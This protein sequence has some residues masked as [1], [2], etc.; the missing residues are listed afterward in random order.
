[1]SKFLYETLY[2]L[3]H[4]STR[5]QTHASLD[6]FFIDKIFPSIASIYPLKSSALLLV[7]RED[8]I[9][10][11][12]SRDS[13]L[14]KC[15]FEN[16][17][18]SFA[19]SSAQK[20]EF[21]IKYDKTNLYLLKN[22]PYMLKK[23]EYSLLLISENEIPEAFSDLHR[24]S[25]SLENLLLENERQHVSYKILLKYLDAVDDGISACDKDGNVTYINSSACGLI[26]ADKSKIIGKNL[27]HP[28]FKDTI[29]IQILKSK[30]P[31]MDFEYN[32]NYSGKPSHLMNSAYPVFDNDG[33]IMGAIDIFRRIKRSYQIASSMAGH[34]AT[35]E[36]KDFIGSGPTLQNKINLAK[37][38]SNINKNTLLEGESGTGKDLFSQ[39]IHNFSDRK[40]GP[41][42]AINCANYPIDLFDSELFGYDEGAFTGA[43]K[44][45]KSGKFELADGGTLFLDEIGEM[46]MQL[47]AKLLR[48][49]E[50][51]QVTRL[52]S[53]K[54][55][56]T[57]VRIIAATNRNLESM[58]KKKQFREDLYYRLKVLYLKIPPLRERRED[59]K[60][61]SEHF[62]EKINPE[63]DKPVSRLS[64]EAMELIRAYDWPGNIRQLENILSIAMFMSGG[65]I[66][67]KSH[68]MQAGLECTQKHFQETKK[69]E[70]SS[71]EILKNALE[72]NGYNIKQTSEALGISRNTIYRKMKKYGIERL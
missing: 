61:L 12:V 69:L 57:D 8:R 46:P 71:M 17:M 16:R 28:P 58:I 26:G 68:L 3:T 42:V 23:P 19:E 72:E 20:H 60:E 36:F 21:M 59:L 41:F 50:T 48:A 9:L 66:L 40:S 31:Q 13:D 55:I 25:K 52:G 56:T 51:K 35:Y 15:N 37:E 29:L 22:I 49:I 11:I 43:K 53:N 4:E 18:F 6:E 65:G 1:M 70:D 45:G 27:N 14:K 32:L 67:E 24:I 47:Q 38:F 10:S 44:G 39:S 34:R 7:D 63:M 54:T 30:K 62:I 64:G 33:K 5:P 2:A